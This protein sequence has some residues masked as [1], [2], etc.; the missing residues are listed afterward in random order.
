[1]LPRA[2]YQQRE[3]KGIPCFCAPATHSINPW[4]TPIDELHKD[5][6]DYFSVVQGK[7]SAHACKIMNLFTKL[8]SS[9][10]NK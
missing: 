1:M 7:Y 2:K 3:G 10:R 4:V 9:Y 6:D 5:R 8:Y